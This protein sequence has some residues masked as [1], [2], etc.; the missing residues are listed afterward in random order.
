MRTKPRRCL[1]TLRVCTQIVDLLANFSKAFAA[2]L[3]F[4]SEA[5]LTKASLLYAK[6]EVLQ[7]YGLTNPCLQNQRFCTQIE[8]ATLAQLRL[9]ALLRRAA[10]GLQAKLCVQIYDLQGLRGHFVTP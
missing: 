5:V 4:A 3:R 9:L 1:K 2:N 8:A 7:A 10:E 6:P